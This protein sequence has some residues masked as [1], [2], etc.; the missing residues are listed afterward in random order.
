[1]G[2]DTV[3]TK[4]PSIATG[5][6]V[7]TPGRASTAMSEYADAQSFIEV[8]IGMYNEVSPLPDPNNWRATDAILRV[9]NGTRA[10]RSDAM[11]VM[12]NGVTKI[13]ALEA[14]TIVFGGLRIDIMSFFL[15]TQADIYEN[16]A[17]IN[18]LREELADTKAELAY[19]GSYRE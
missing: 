12:K 14:D 15:R 9:G 17:L 16:R 4:V 19:R 2:N 8:V 11:S 1:M 5:S 10:H 13:K 6:S 18:N 7:V 3:V